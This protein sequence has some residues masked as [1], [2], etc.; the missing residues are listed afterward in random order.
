MLLFRFRPRFRLTEVASMFLRPKTL[1]TSVMSGCY[2]A[3]ITIIAV[4]QLPQLATTMQGKTRQ[5]CFYLLTKLLAEFLR[6]VDANEWL[7]F[8]V[9]LLIWLL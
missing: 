2:I 9:H 1:M 8:T 7:T 4:T 3:F 5:L 6:T